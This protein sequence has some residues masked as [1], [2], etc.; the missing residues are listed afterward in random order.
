MKMN[1]LFLGTGDMI[2]KPEQ[3]LSIKEFN[4]DRKVDFIETL[5]WLMENFP[6]FKNTMLSFASKTILE[7]EPL[8]RKSLQK[9]ISSKEEDQD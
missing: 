3:R 8:I 7:T 5:L 4:F 1:Y 6:F 9:N 2:V